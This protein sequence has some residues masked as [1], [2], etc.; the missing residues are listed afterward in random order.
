[1]CCDSR[2]E[3][4]LWHAS[5]QASAQGPRLCPC[6]RSLAFPSFPGLP[7]CTPPPCVP[8]A[9]LLL[10]TVVLEDSSLLRPPAGVTNGPAPLPFP[11]SRSF[12]LLFTPCLDPLSLRNS[13]LPLLLCPSSQ[14]SRSSFWNPGTASPPPAPKRGAFKSPA[15]HISQDLFVVTES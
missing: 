8:R 4:P 9:L 12:S 10:P 14:P 3:C 15:P 7:F 2:A 6:P 13:S 1:M 11:W 5:D